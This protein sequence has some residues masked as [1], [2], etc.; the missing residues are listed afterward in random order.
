MSEES[1]LQP[2]TTQKRFSKKPVIVIGFFILFL[3]LC[4]F[5][6]RIF[7][8]RYLPETKVI[9]VPEGSSFQETADILQ[10][11]AIIHSSLAAQILGR[12][13]QLSV[14][15]GAY[16]FEDGPQYLTQVLER[17]KKGD[18]GD[19]YT[20]ITIPEGSSNKEISVLLE[21]KIPGFDKNLFEKETKDK[22]GYLFPDTYFF[23]PDVGTQEII[24][25]F[26]TTFSTK[27]ESLLLENSKRELD[28]IVI[29][30]SLIE[31]EAGPSFDEQQMVAGILWK[32]LDE[33]IPLQVDAPFV[34]A[35][36]KGS[37]ELRTSD[38]RNDGPYNTYTRKGLTP[39]PI[40]NPGLS[41]LK[42]ALDPKSSPYYFYLHDMEG[43]IHYGVTH[44][45]HV[46]NKQQYLR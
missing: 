19:V 17:L 24:D 22:E 10:S 15:A 11:E 37:S 4:L 12:I 43:N 9:I 28:D 40:G 6:F 42:A 20:R 33:G 38:L 8:P 27:T 46:K 45:D 41:A 14:Q 16:E 31:R 25:T 5:G 1:Y 18:F 34:Y 26:Y 36:G 13:N 2:L 44:D 39:T 3:F 29:M 30:A 7:S 21:K 23:L 32:R 35:I